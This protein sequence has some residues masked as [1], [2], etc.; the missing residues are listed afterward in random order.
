MEIVEIIK[1]DNNLYE[2]LFSVIPSAPCDNGPEEDEDV[3]VDPEDEVE[4]KVDYLLAG[5][6]SVPERIEIKL[7]GHRENMWAISHSDGIVTYVPV[8]HPH[9]KRFEK[10]HNEGTEITLANAFKQV[11]KRKVDDT[12]L[13]DQDLS[14][15]RTPP[16]STRTASLQTSMEKA[17]DD[18]VR[19][20]QPLIQTRQSYLKRA[21]LGLPPSSILLRTLGWAKYELEYRNRFQPKANR[22][23][24]T[25]AAWELLFGPSHY[26]LSS[27]Q[28]VNVDVHYA[29]YKHGDEGYDVM[30]HKDGILRK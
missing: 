21:N 7:N 6:D 5:A 13:E 27:D 22:H 25:R 3:E 24:V 30:A 12:D 19:N 15:Q 17:R 2:K 16:R 8:N 9:V 28:L 26:N 1:G 10:M 20:I 4:T 18:K 11:R 29:R 14:M 23:A